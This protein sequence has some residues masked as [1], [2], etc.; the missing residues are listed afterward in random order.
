M[1]NPA[2]E[3]SLPLE[4]RLQCSASLDKPD[5]SERCGNVIT[6]R[7]STV[8]HRN[9]STM[10]VTRREIRTRQS[11]PSVSHMSSRSDYSFAFISLSTPGHA[12]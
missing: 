1:R 11:I 3:I 12:T 8:H 10:A 7:A 9:S 5:S 6:A 4:Y 2:F